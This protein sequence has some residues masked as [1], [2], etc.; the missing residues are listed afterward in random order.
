MEG[1]EKEKKEGKK[2]KGENNYPLSSKILNVSTIN[3][4]LF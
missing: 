2:K 4:Q 3:F 1:K